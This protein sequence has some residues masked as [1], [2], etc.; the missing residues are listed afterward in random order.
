[1]DSPTPSLTDLATMTAM[2]IATN[3]RAVARATPPPLNNFSPEWLQ[4]VA[5]N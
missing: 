1:M 2:R 5:N 3:G 4:H